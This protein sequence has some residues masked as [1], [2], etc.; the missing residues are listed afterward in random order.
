MVAK[1]YHVMEHIKLSHKVVEARWIEQEAKWTIKVQ[2][3]DG[4]VFEDKAD[5]LYALVSFTVFLPF[6]FRAIADC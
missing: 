3:P 2:G 1:K 4:K 6:S 5:M